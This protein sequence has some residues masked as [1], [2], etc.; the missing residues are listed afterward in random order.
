[1]GVAGPSTRNQRIERLWREVFRCVCHYYYYIFYAME[2]SGLLNID[3]KLHLFVLHLI[4]IPRINYALHEYANLFNDHKIRTAG[5]MSPNQLWLNGMLDINNPLSH[6]ALDKD[7]EDFDHYAEDINGPTPF[8]DSSNNVVV[9]P[10][11]VSHAD[12]IATSVLQ[13]VDPLMESTEMGTDIFSKA[14]RHVEE[15]F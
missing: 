14:L 15:N 8:D 2:Q 3:N 4:F 7:P 1:M 6:G 12:I 5:N 11:D 10:I 13:V 9:L